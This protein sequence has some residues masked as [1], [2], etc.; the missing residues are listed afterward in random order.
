[1]TI[2]IENAP[3]RAAVH[4]IAVGPR[5]Q[6]MVEQGRPMEDA[7][8]GCTCGAVV[9]SGTWEN[10]RGRT[11]DQERLDRAHRAWKERQA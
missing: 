10:H 4:R 9:T 11:A 5:F 8:I 6:L 3:R 1:M 2:H 7:P